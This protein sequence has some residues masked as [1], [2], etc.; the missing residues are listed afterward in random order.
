MAEGATRDVGVLLGHG[1]AGAFDWQGQLATDLAT[2]LAQ[3]GYLVVR[4]VGPPLPEVTRQRA[5]EKV[6]DAA[7][8]SP[9]ARLTPRWVLAGLGP[10]ARVA[11]VVGARARSSIAAE[12]LIGYPLAAPMPT[13]KGS[14]MP[15]SCMP[16]LRVA[17]PALLVA[18][19]GDAACP[20]AA[21][22]SAV[23]AMASGDV[24]LVVAQ[25]V[26]GAF[27]APGADPPGS[28]APALRSAICAS[29]LEF[30]GAAA[31]GRLE[32]CA[33]QRAKGPDDGPPTGSALTALQQAQIR[34]QEEDAL[35][36]Q[37]DATTL[38]PPDGAQADAA[39]AAPDA[40]EVAGGAA[41]A[42]QRQGAAGGEQQQ[43]EDQPGEPMAQ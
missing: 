18:G 33:L 27:S 14:Q 24:R 22:R 21:L 29:V 35:A 17:P 3:A 1:G 6:L 16:L 40:A 28:V 31:A 34:M 12:V 9:F 32:Q 10:G 7:A 2:A 38:L 37:Q 41:D 42:E 19:D 20:V 15:D 43:L 36:Y 5:F 25:G 11:A 26:D 39:A 30:V 13:I 23:K 4:D 8:T